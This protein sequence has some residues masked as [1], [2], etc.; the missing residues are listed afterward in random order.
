MAAIDAARICD[1]F[2]DAGGDVT[3]DAFMANSAALTACQSDEI[4]DITP[5]FTPHAMPF[6]IYERDPAY[7]RGMD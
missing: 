4:E 3:S 6:K 2:Y 7:H 5:K 1:E